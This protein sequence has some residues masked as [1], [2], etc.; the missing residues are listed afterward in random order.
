MRRLEGFVVSCSLVLFAA[1]D[2]GAGPPWQQS[3]LGPQRD[4]R[5]IQELI[6]A[7]IISK[8][9]DALQID[10]EQFA[11]MIVAQKNLQQHRRD[12]QRQRGAILREL[13]AMV[14]GS[15]SPEDEVAARLERLEELK[16]EFEASSREDY[17]KIDAILTVHQRA[18]YRLLEVMVERRM[19]ELVQ[20]VRGRQ[21]NPDR[22]RPNR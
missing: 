10:D 16:S 6:D 14:R 22:R 20:K 15:E 18:R 8:M 13:Q 2:L 1:A 7:Y 3:P 17:R 19:Q 9:Q 11:K 12:Y 21:G 5:E 4:G